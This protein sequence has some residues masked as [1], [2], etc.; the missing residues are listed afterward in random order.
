MKRLLLLEADHTFRLRLV[1][2]LRERFD[3]AVPTPEEDPLR[4][5]RAARPDLALLAAGDRSRAQ[6]IRLARVLK[7]DIRVVPAVALYCRPGED[8]PSA[9]AFATTGADGYAAD[10]ESP[11]ALLVLLSALERG[12]HPIPQPWPRPGRSVVGR[13]LARFKR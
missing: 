12:E 2:A 1:A 5:A 4:F 3:L 7:T 10:V 9:A 6:A 13:L 8:G 11:E